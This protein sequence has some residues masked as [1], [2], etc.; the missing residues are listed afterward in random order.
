MS[1]PSDVAGEVLGIDWKIVASAFA[2]F[3]GT[4]VTSIWGW[5]QGQKKASNVLDNPNS[6]QMQVVGA[7]L[8]DNQSLRENTNALIALRDQIVILNHSLPKYMESHDSTQ[9]EI[10]KLLRRLDKVG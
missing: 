6:H 5:M 9:E 2:V 8:Q 10:D 3:V 1:P 4:L 7:V